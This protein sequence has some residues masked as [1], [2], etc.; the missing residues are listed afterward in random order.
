MTK[1]Q[2]NQFDAANRVKQHG[3]DHPLIPAIAAA[4]AAYTALDGSIAQV[5]VL[6][7]QRLNGSGTSAGATQE[8]QRLRKQLRSSLS[9]LSR[10]SKTLDKA[11]Y[12]DVAAQLKIGRLN[13]DAQL[14]AYANNALAVVEPIKAVFIAHGAATTV[15]EDLETL[16]AD[17]IA[18][19]GRGNGGRGTRIGSNAGLPVAIRACMAQVRIL[20]GIMSILLKPTPGLLAEWKA[21]KRVRRGSV[22]EEEPTVP[23]PPAPTP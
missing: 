6:D 1:Q 7:S 20:D 4:T 13:S 9:D 5:L 22:P 19:G 8:R 15:V 17:F 12:P 3:I 18:V 10:V 11:T 21:A 2:R 23:P 14:L 16:V